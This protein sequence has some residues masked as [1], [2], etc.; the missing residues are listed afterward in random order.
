MDQLFIFIILMCMG[1]F[2]FAFFMKQYP[3]EGLYGR[4]KDGISLFMLTQLPVIKNILDYFERD[5][6]GKNYLYYQ[7]FLKKNESN[8]SFR[9]VYFIKLTSC[10]LVTVLLILVQ[11]TNILTYEE[12]IKKT[13]K[14]DMFIDQIKTDTQYN[15]NLYN[16]ATKDIGNNNLKK[17]T[18][19]ERQLAINRYLKNFITDQGVIEEK[20][21]YIMKVFN[22]ISSLSFINFYFLFI[23]LFSYFIPEICICLKKVFYNGRYRTELTKL[24]NI[25]ML[26]GSIP[27]YKTLEI[28]KE[29]AVSSK[30]YRK[31]LLACKETYL[32]DKQLALENLKAN[33]N[34]SKFNKLVDILKIYSQIDKN[35]ALEILNRN[36]IEKEED[37][38][39]S[40][41]ENIDIIDIFA[42]F[43]I[44]PILFFLSMLILSPGMEI[45]SKGFEFYN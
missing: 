30:I 27:G 21:K 15:Y 2:A 9:E 42:L 39:L 38:I 3:R 18:N 35:V 26:L 11:I 45:I 23:I 1:I 32:I 43:A 4:F 5:K 20:T 33:I 41:N 12:I 19:Q 44:L 8:L 37:L 24:E 31:H 40:A 36:Y 6:N 14:V 25:F 7:R 22:K 10:F 17:M 28:I 34:F 29:M 13:T 16:T